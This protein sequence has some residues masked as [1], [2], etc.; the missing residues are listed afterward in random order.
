MCPLQQARDDPRGWENLLEV[1]ED[2]QHP[3]AADAVRDR[4]ERAAP[5]L[6]REPERLAD[7]AADT[8][9]RI[10]YRRQWYECHA[11]GKG[12]RHRLSHLDRQARLARPTRPGQGQEP[13][14]VDQSRGSVRPPAP[15][16]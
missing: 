5:R 7:R 10:Q 3:A 14:P 12:I 8:S 11:I 16:R 4:L 1:I 2:Q 15:D 13:C 9:L 6:F